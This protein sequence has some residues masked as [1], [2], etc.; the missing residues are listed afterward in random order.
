MVAASAAMKAMA[1]TVMMVVQPAGPMMM[2]GIPPKM[3]H[4]G[5][6]ILSHLQLNTIFFVSS[7]VIGLY[8]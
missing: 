4:R 3:I 8:G 1:I 7:F 5:S 2:S 6:R